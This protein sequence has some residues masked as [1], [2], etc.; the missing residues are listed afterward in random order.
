MPFDLMFR[1]ANGAAL[2][3]WIGLALLPRFRFLRQAM[4][5]VVVGGLCVLYTVLINVYFFRVEG[6]GFSSLGTV[7]LLFQSPAVALAGWVHYLAFDL[8][9]GGWI[10]DRSDAIG[11]S[12]WVQ[13][14]VLVTTFMFGP[15]GL[16]IFVAMEQ[17][18]RLRP[19]AL[20]LTSPEQK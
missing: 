12:R 10:A 13:A 6:G 16:L 11:L 14:P 20:P 5:V 15:I 8:L 3:C 17:M 1:V 19:L 9:V 7:Q 4:H 18:Q 2:A